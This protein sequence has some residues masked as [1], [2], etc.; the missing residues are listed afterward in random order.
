MGTARWGRGLAALALMIALT[1]C[2]GDESD[3]SAS[4]G[5]ATSETTTA[6]LEPSTT[7][8]SPSSTTPVQT[9]PPAQTRTPRTTTTAVRSRTTAPAVARASTTTTV[10]GAVNPPGGITSHGGPVRDH[11]SL[12]DNLR[13]RGLTVT[14][15][16]AISQP[17][18]RGD[19]TIL[20]VSGPGVAATTLQSF[21]YDSAAAAAADAATFGPDGNPKTVMVGWIGAPHLYVR[22]RVLVIYVGSDTAMTGLLT[23][24]LGPQFSGR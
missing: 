22:E 4:R 13:G 19:G 16:S 12:V 20:A 15:Q 1:G 14:P 11:V 5:V 2:G 21:Q 3:T 18:L 9:T 24:L 6:S 8:P 17:F 10:P 7:N 23:E